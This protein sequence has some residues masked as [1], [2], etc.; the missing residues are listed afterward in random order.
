ME[1]DPQPP[2]PIKMPVTWPDD[3][4]FEELPAG[5][6]RRVLVALERTNNG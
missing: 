4:P 1:S 6:Q 5:I 2:Y 3:T